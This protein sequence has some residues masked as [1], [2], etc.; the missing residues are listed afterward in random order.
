MN[1]VNI[2]NKSILNISNMLRERAK[3]TE[4][5]VQELNNLADTLEKAKSILGFN[6]FALA[7]AGAGIAKEE[8]PEVG[9]EVTPVPVP[10]RGFRLTPAAK[11]K[12]LNWLKE[13]KYTVKWIAEHL[14]I[15]RAAVYQLRDKHGLTNYKR[16]GVAA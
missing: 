15:T 5:R 9:K 13:G 16:Q 10:Q 1:N 2:S 4:L 7:L 12:G 11:E 8:A 3:E 6:E 14:G